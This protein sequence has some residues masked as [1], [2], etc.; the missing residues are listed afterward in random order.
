MIREPVRT[1]A[2]AP[3][4]CQVCETSRRVQIVAI[5]GWQV[6]AFMPCPHCSVKDALEIRHYPIRIDIPR[7]GAA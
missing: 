2:S 1:V 4:S 3:T 6:T 7:G 5:S